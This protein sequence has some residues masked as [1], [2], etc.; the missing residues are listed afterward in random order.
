MAIFW[1]DPYI[2][3]P[4]GGVDGT[5]GVGTLGSYANPYSIDNL[6][7]TSSTYTNGDEVRLKALPANPWLTDSLPAWSP[8]SSIGGN[9]GAYFA[10]SP[11]QHSFIKYTSIKGEKTYLSWNSTNTN[12][13]KSYPPIW[14]GM[15]PYAD[16]TLPAYK[17]DPQYYLLSLIHI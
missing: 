16:V 10:F 6:P 13:T 4:S 3:S 15:S 8:S 12:T 11:D 1:C 2:E 7:S 14:G 9:F 17:L 5:T